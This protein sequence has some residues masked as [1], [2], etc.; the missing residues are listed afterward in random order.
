[1]N[2]DVIWEMAPDKLGGMQFV[3]K[4]EFVNLFNSTIMNLRYLL[5]FGTTGEVVWCMIEA[6]GWI[7]SIQ[8]MLKTSRSLMDYPP[9]ERM[10]QKDSKVM[11]IM[12][13]IKASSAYMRNATQ[14]GGDTEW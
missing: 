10:C 8:S 14:R 12:G 1:M 13:K 3:P 9:K 7:S 6:Y 11:V 5:V 4:P 2:I